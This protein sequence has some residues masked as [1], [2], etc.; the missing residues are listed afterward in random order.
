[1]LSSPNYCA[2]A[3]ANAFFVALLFI[4]LILLHSSISSWFLPCNTTEVKIPRFLEM[5]GIWEQEINFLSYIGGK[6][7][8]AERHKG[9]LR[10]KKD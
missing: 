3:L 1:M 10:S 9:T 8:K 5:C 2:V 7:R 6:E 4:S